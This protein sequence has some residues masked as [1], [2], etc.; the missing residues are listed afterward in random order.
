MYDFVA[1]D[2][3][4]ANENLNSACSIGIV[5]VKDLEIAEYYESFIQPPYNRFSDSNIFIHGITPNMT[6]RAPT[7]NEIWSDISAFFS[8]HT[9]V[10]AHNA[11]FDMSVLRLSTSADIPDFPYIDTI[12]L[13]TPFV[14]GSKSLEHCAEWFGIEMDQHHNALSDATATAEI[15][16]KIL[17]ESDCASMWELLAFARQVDIHMF[18]DL[19]PQ[20][21]FFTRKKRTPMPNYYDFAQKPSDISPTCKVDEESPLY[22]KSIV[23][24]GE[25][26]IPRPAAWQAAV[27]C[28]AKIRTSVSRRTDY[29]VV[30]EQEPTFVGADGLSSKQR[31]ALAL[32]ADGTG[33]IIIL[34]EKEFFA[35]TGIEE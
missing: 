26:S 15:A 7:L 20:E 4:T 24:T 6:E 8:E 16:I 3:E 12:A 32:N 18:A 1:I 2:F 5:A 25:L 10:I 23:F 33:H 27:N 19:V 9:P 28:G 14:D 35:L 30:G 11:H 31:N 34:N 17:E 29:L 21:R 22:G 13:A